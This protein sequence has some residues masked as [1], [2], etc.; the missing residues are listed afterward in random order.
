MDKKQADFSGV[1]NPKRVIEKRMAEAE[2]SE[3]PSSSPKTSFTK[4]FTPAERAKQA[5]ALQRYLATRK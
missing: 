4:P 1:L 3:Q 5:E 2:R